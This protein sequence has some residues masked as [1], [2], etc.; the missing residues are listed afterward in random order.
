M[1]TCSFQ[2]WDI[3]IMY[4]KPETIQ[5]DKNVNN[6]SEKTIDLKHAKTKRN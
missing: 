3:A 2:Q 5:Y 1:P 4:N 6:L